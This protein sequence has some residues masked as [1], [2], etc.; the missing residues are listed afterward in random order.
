MS[1]T[2]DVALVDFDPVPFEITPAVRSGMEQTL[3]AVGAQLRLAQARSEAA[4]LDFARSADLVMI[5]SVRPMLNRAVIPQLACRAIIRMGLGFDS[6]DVAAATE[7][8]ILVSNVVD[9]CNDEV[10]DHAAGAA[11]GRFAPGRARWTARCIPVC[12][13]AARRWK[14]CACAERR[15]ASSALAGLARRWP[16]AW[17]PLARC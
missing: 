7:R 10:A 5:Q 12:G 13:T 8:G 2:F 3:A 9:W 14:S 17:C 4:V 15:S 16:S 1:A 11:A 6:V